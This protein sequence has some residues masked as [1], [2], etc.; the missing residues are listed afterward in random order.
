M[1]DTGGIK[2]RK[3]RGASQPDGT[4]AAAAA[5]LPQRRRYG[6]RMGDAPPQGPP[7]WLIT[8]TDVMAL[9]LTF[10]VL[11]FAMA[12]PTQ[13]Q[14][15]ELTAALQSE[16]NNFYGASALRG[17]TDAINLARIDYN[18]ALNI[19]Y[20]RALLESEMADNEQLASLRLISQRGQLIISMPDE[21]LFAS[22]QAE[23]SDAGARTLY[24]LGGTL[25][26]IRNKIE[27]VGNA[28]PRPIRDTQGSY[29][30]NWH[31]SM[32][33]AASVAAILQKVGYSRP[34][35]LRGRGS[36][37]YQDLQ[38]IAELSEEQRLDVSRRVDIVIAD[39]DGR[40]NKVFLDMKIK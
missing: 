23:V 34:I 38:A 15:E 9:M 11:L 39:H 21:M 33:R 32:A 2:K 20:L 31:L 10:F 14:W 29:A 24:A 8:F 19:D 28:D 26:R 35:T 22:G 18:D 12:V 6:R 4:M 13:E 7:I 16:L 27:V 3:K 25:N 17:P 36:G 40:R 5:P 37:R 1:S 30:N